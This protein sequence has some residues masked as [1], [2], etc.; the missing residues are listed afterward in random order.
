[1]KLAETILVKNNDD[2][3]YLIIILLCNYSLL[4][5]SC[6]ITKIAIHFGMNASVCAFLIRTKLSRRSRAI[7]SIKTETN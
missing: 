2:N 7:R 6:D 1:M 3:V 4:L 5:F